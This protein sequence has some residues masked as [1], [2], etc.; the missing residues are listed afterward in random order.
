MTTPLGSPDVMFAF[1]SLA[2]G[3]LDVEELADRLYEI[4][5]EE[6]SAIGDGLALLDH[7]HRLGTLDSAAVERIT[8]QLERAAR[9]APATGPG[10]LST[11]V[12][13]RLGFE[14]DAP[15]PSD[16]ARA[17]HTVSMPYELRESGDRTRSFELTRSLDSSVAAPP[18]EHTAAISVPRS[19]A[20]RP[21]TEPSMPSLEPVRSEPS[22]LPIRRPEA[23]A[24]TESP[25]AAQRPVGPGTVLRNRY[26]LEREIGSGGMGTV[27]R[28][29]DRNRLGLPEE[30]R[31]IAVKV[32]HPELAAR[33]DALQTLRQEFYQAQSLSHPGIVNVF[34][35][36]QDAHVHFMTMELLD[37]ELLGDLLVRIQPNRLR[38]DVAMRLLRDLG[39]AVA[40]AHEHGVLHRDLKPG[41]VMVSRQGEIRVL[42]FGLGRFQLN[43]PWISESGMSFDAATPTYASAERLSGKYPDSRD[44]IFSFA[45]V[46]YEVLAGRHP[47]ARKS[48]VDAREARLKPRRIRGLSGRQWRTLKQGLAWSRDDRPGTMHEMLDG[49]G[50]RERI[51]TGDGPQQ[52]TA[53]RRTA[54]TVLAALV[55]IAVLGFAGWTLYEQRDGWTAVLPSLSPAPA[56]SSTSSAKPPAQSSSAGVAI[57]PVVTNDPAT[58]D[59]VSASADTDPGNT[60]PAS[61]AAT[62]GST[63]STGAAEGAA[64]ATQ[65]ISVAAPPVSS[66]PGKLSFTVGNLPVSESASTARL[67]VRRTGGSAGSVSFAWRT[68]D[69]SAVGG[70]DFAPAAGV[71][72][73]MGPGQTTAT[74]LIPLVGDSVREPTRLFDVVIDDFTGGAARGAITRATVVIVDDD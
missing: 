19:S 39:V 69:D 51:D 17:G 44:D 23:S 15:S 27:Y 43:E 74:V 57:P 24:D 46:A 10:E 54:A 70:T 40:Y 49:L 28:A 45:C 47:F 72:E 36:D 30:I 26:V 55:A 61:A 20:S 35:F 48:A 18:V 7:Y 21:R 22:V 56:L 67:T 58:A 31:Y 25:A 37:G 11:Y 59:N 4:C 60:T 53:W 16:S 29:L 71:R 1:D 2:S 14:A 41:N 6:T 52:V 62:T 8:A 3:A 33:K 34:D 73:T 65:P 64:G 50:M 68:I 5:S 13:Q 63:T 12:S 66:S 38:R 9:E 42:D 32:L